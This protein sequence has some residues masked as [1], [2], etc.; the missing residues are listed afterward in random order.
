MG[1]VEEY[2]PRGGKKPTVTYFK[3][4]GNFLGAA[5]K[6]ERKKQKPK[7]KSENDDGY[8]SDEIVADDDQSFKNCG[9]CLNY[10]IVKEGQVFLGRVR[11]VLETRL[12]I[13]LPCRLFGT[14]MA[15]H[16]SE[17]YNKI[18]EA[19]VNDQTDKVQDLN[20]MFRP[21]QYVGVK[22]LEVEANNLML[23][24]M[25]QHVNAG[26]PHNELHK[27]AMLQAAVSSVEDHGY[28]MELGISNTRAFLPK[29]A[30]NTELELETGMLTWCCVKSIVV[31]N[32][33]SV[34]T[35]SNNL[36]ALRGAVQRRHSTALYPATALE[37]TIDKSLD[38]GI[39]GHVFQ[40]TVAYV[41]R[42]QVDKVKGKKPNFGQKVRARVLYVLPTRNT[43]FLTM[44][45]IFEYTYPDLEKE[46]KYKTGDII[47]EAQVIKIM[48]RCIMFKLGSG[49]IGSLSLRRIQV[50]EEL[51]DEDVIAKSYPIGSTHVVRVLTYNLSDYIYS[52]S[53]EPSVLSEKIFTMSDLTVGDIVSATVRSVTDNRLLLSV[54]RVTD[55]KSSAMSDLVIVNH[56]QVRV[57]FTHIIEFLLRYVQHHDVFLHSIVHKT[58]M[59]D[60]G[61]YV[62]PKKASNAQMTKK[63]KEGQRVKA[64]VWELDIKKAALK[65]TLKPSLLLP[66]LDVL[67]RYEDAVEG[68]TYTGVIAVIR[69]YLLVSFFNGL[70]CYVPRAHVAQP[71]PD[72]LSDILHVG[73]IVNCTIL[74]V[75]PE[76]KK[77]TGSLLADPFKFWKNQKTAEKRQNTEDPP[78]LKKKLKKTQSQEESKTSD[79]KGKSKKKSESIEDEDMAMNVEDESKMSKKKKNIKKDKE[80]T[81][82]GENVENENLE[83]ESKESNNEETSTTEK[84]TRKKKKEAERIETDDDFLELDEIFSKHELNDEDDEVNKNKEKVKKRKKNN[85]D[86]QELTNETKGKTNKK[87]KTTEIQ[88]DSDE[89]KIP[90][91][92]KRKESVSDKTTEE[93]DAIETDI[94]EDSD[95]M[96]TPQDQGLIDLSDC[97]NPKQYKRRI[98]SLL[99]VIQ[100]KTRRIDRIDEKIEALVNRGITV[101]SKKFHTAMLTEKLLIEKSIE[102][103]L[104]ALKI[105]QD[106]FK[107]FNLKTKDKK[108]KEKKITDLIQF[109]GKESV[110]KVDKPVQKVLDVSQSVKVQS[111]ESVLEVPSV[112]EFWSAPAEP[113]PATQEQD[114]SSSSEEQEEEKPKKKRKKLRAAERVAKA[115]EEEEKIRSLESAQAA[116]GEAPRSAEQFERA[117]LASPDCSQL[118]I[119]YMAF[120]LQ[121]ISTSL[122]PNERAL[123]ASPDCSQLWIAYMAFHLQATEIE[124]AR[125]VGR[126]A[127]RTICFRE[128]QEKLNIWLALLNLEHRF[129]TKESQQKTLE[130]A[131]Q[132]NE[133][134]QI[135]SK[136]LDIYVETGKAGEA[137]ALAELML[138]K[139][140]RQLEAYI[141]AGSACYQLGLLEKA[142]QIMQKGLAALEKREHVALLVRFAQLERGC[143]DAERAGALLEHVLAAYPQRVDVTSLYVDMLL[144]SNDI[145][146][147]R[148]LMERMTSQK[149]PARKMKVLF[150]KWIEVEE[151]IGDQQQVDNIRKRAVE[152]IEK[153]QF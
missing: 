153:A 147:V 21:G 85:E 79:K 77:M 47:E 81:V 92:K 36:E 98:I 112:K 141:A 19:Y 123:L 60:A 101:G 88:T 13:S 94:Y 118:W 53:D 72:T 31:E 143:G 70:H 138:R 114:S 8:L 82:D 67:H 128:E 9:I 41:Q 149:L 64:R 1:D 103:L 69:D 28:V 12:N 129:G 116:G 27:G 30:S 73:Q 54:G 45:D 133:K 62:D 50:D 106:K 137:G 22:V 43:P 65:L 56:S 63:F 51:T 126:R 59:S 134:Y 96:L 58:H 148:Q 97:N 131:L 84:K 2:F 33:N 48:G 144:K 55:C 130:E 105:A 3:Q 37:F 17:A 29:N 83:N 18:L 140:R 80:I 132:M 6:G 61:C 108:K 74:N 5:E 139:Y 49:C 52:L 57:D 122:S 150:K 23:S 136:L 95:N 40:D 142:R 151:K 10:K 68:K 71:P 76:T 39:E 42:Q 78:I 4:S 124:K 20:Q 111:V 117:L 146:R 35:L 25:P 135:H 11:D 26:R 46:Q 16:V 109:V 110:T 91:K 24:M 86:K 125:G 38:N 34:L 15:C 145:E 75:S 93:S 102:K 152:F 127:L 89:E 100:R 90:D 120:H 107:E 66:D 44:K 121:V 32:E 87:K 119:A 104:E 99:K 14:V 115:R 7:K 113:P